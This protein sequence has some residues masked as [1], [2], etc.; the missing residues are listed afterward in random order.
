MTV[1]ET[2]TFL[3]FTAGV[4]SAGFVVGRIFEKYKNDRL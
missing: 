1:F 4:F 2:M 3:T